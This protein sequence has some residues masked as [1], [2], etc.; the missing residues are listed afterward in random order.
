[1][2]KALD[3]GPLILLP[4]HFIGQPAH[5]EKISRV[6]G[7]GNEDHEDAAHAIGPFADGSRVGSAIRT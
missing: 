2:E 4:V 5:M 6:C 7:P 3:A 1:M